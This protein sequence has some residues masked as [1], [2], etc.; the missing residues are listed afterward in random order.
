MSTLLHR[1]IPVAVRVLQ[2][3]DGL[4]EYVA[5][6]ESMD[7]Y[8][9]VIRVDGW[10]F[11]RFAKNS[12]FLNSHRSGSVEDVLGKVVSYE[13][14]GGRL[15]EVVQWAIDV[16]S[17]QLS[18][19]GWDMTRAGYL[20]AV[21]VGFYP[22]RMVS[23]WDED[24]GAFRAEAE[25]L[26]IDPNVLRAVYLEQEQIELSA[27]VVGA[28]GNAL[29]QMARAHKDGVLSDADI[30]TL[31]RSIA[32]VPPAS[33]AYG[34]TGPTAE[35]QAIARRREAFLGKFQAAIRR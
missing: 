6:D 31:S 11:N 26:K 9:E 32:N 21:S 5:S 20:K 24:K 13:I 12:P 4:V 14:K 34:D 22:V 2:G 8:R 18:R 10:R 25:K 28:N 29:L 30:E 15:V 35:K 19:I 7:S 16:P 23:R 27:V 17:N 3:A 1:E 33:S